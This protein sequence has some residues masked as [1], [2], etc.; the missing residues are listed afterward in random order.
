[1]FATHGG[2]LTLPN[3][4]I[5][6]EFCGVGGASLFVSKQCNKEWVATDSPLSRN[7]SRKGNHAQFSVF[8]STTVVGDCRTR[9]F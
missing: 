8:G 3:F 4:C 7:S 2:Q 5:K 1:M 6:Q 9:N